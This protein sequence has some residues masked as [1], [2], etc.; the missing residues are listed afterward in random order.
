MGG[1]SKNLKYRRA[2]EGPVATE[3]T[4]PAAAGEGVDQERGKHSKKE[5]VGKRQEV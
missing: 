5:S 2:N 3:T 4:Q 1:Q